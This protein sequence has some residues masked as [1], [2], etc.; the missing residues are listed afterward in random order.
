MVNGIGLLGIAKKAGSW[1]L[2]TSCR[3]AGR[4]LK[5]RVMLAAWDSSRNSKRAE[6]LAKA[7]KS[8]LWIC[9]TEKRIWESRSGEVAGILAITD[10]GMAASFLPSLRPIFAASMTAAAELG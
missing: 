10:I 8:A 6:N 9:R 1:R 5:G 3:D 7:G 4:A 2:V